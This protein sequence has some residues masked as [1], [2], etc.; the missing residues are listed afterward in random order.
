[1]KMDLLYTNLTTEVKNEIKNLGAKIEDASDY[2]H[3][4]RV[5]IYYPEEKKKDYFSIL[6]KFGLLQNSLSYLTS[7]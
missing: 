5:S 7:K 2:I 1:M 3:Q 4:E 6:R